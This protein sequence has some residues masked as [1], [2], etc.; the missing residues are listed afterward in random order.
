MARMRDTGIEVIL[1][2]ERISTC[3]GPSPSSGP[4]TDTSVMSPP[5]V[6]PNIATTRRN[7]SAGTATVHD[8]YGV[9]SSSGESTGCKYGFAV[10]AQMS[11]I[12]RVRDPALDEYSAWAGESSYKRISR[13]VRAISASQRS[14]LTE[15]PGLLPPYT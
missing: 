8:R 10:A 11:W 2:S 7:V 9:T 6:I 3:E 13:D 12:A 14:S 5:T 1:S 4:T 15:S